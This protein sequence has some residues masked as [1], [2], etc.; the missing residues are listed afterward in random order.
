MYVAG[1]CSF[2]LMCWF[3]YLPQDT[4]LLNLLYT[5]N[6]VLFRSPNSH[7]SN[8]VAELD[9]GLITRRLQN[10]ELFTTKL[11]S[12]K[13]AHVHAELFLK[14]STLVC[15]HS[16]CRSQAPSPSSRL[17]RQVCYLSLPVLQCWAI[18]R[19]STGTVTLNTQKTHVQAGRTL[20]LLSP[21]S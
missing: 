10:T 9:K 5:H 6:E 13:T 19:W 14:H 3:K 16:F 12:A 1:P 11:E 4:V 17:K 7:P 15:L 2:Q 21:C 18:S 8:S 20:P